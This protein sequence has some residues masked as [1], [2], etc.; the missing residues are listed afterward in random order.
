MRHIITRRPL[1]VFSPQDV[2]SI[3]SFIIQVK[4]VFV[5]HFIINIS[6]P[7][8]PSRKDVSVNSGSSYTRHRLPR[9]RRD[10]D[11]LGGLSDLV[12]YQYI[13]KFS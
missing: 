7:G 2:R 4:Y 12:A 10:R 8:K 3:E 5:F 9:Q 6:V 1:L 13:V 11:Y